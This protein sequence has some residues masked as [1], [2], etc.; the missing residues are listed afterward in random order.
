INGLLERGARVVLFAPGGPVILRVVH[1]L[2]G[3]LSSGKTN[4][5]TKLSAKAGRACRAR[6]SASK[7]TAAVEHGNPSHCD[8]AAMLSPAGFVDNRSARP[9]SSHTQFQQFAPQ[10]PF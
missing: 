6:G 3:K 1:K 4:T 8:R 2:P 5:R 9:R 10:V 7:K